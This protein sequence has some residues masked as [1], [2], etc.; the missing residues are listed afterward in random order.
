MLVLPLYSPILSWSVRT[1]ES[2]QDARLLKKSHKRSILTSIVRL[3]TFDSCIKLIFYKKF[4]LLEN[5]QSLI[6]GLQRVEPCI[7]WVI[8]KK[9]MKYL[10]PDVDL[11]MAGPQILVWISSKGLE[12]RE[13]ERDVGNLWLLAIWQEGQTEEQIV[14]LFL[15][16]ETLQL[17]ITWVT[18]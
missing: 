9:R 3:E 6:L 1:R 15:S 18:M 16:Q 2:M 17:C 4:K 5:L 7:S 14:V 8:I 12:A 10:A 13:S 11:S